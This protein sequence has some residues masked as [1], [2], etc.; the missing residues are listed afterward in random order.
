MQ[1]VDR[2]TLLSALEAVSPG[3]DKKASLVQ[4]DCFVFEDDLV[5]TYNDQT[6]CSIQSPLKDYEG[7]AKAEELLS[8]LGKLTEKELRVSHTDAEVLIE[9]KRRRFGIYQEQEIV[10]PGVGDL[11]EDWS[12]LPPEFGDAINLVRHCVSKEKDKFIIC[13]IHLH[14]E[15]VEATD[16]VQL[17]RYTI[18]TGLKTSYLVNPVAMKHVMELGMDEVGETKTW[19]HFRNQA[20]LVFS[21]R[22]Y[23]DRFPEASHLL[24]GTGEKLKLPQGLGEVLEKVEQFTK[25][26]P[27]DEAQVRVTIKGKEFRVKGQGAHGWYEEVKEINSKLN[28]CFYID[29]KLLET[30]AE[31]TPECQIVGARLLVDNGAFKYATALALA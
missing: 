25:N 19:L 22:K 2:N 21:C 27:D 24:E 7:A 15:Y 30:L 1:V 31:K 6:A 18:R 4:S 17:A 10:L 20:G 23:V 13:C 8:I 9:G 16:N 3:L 26:N 11:P 29:P 12:K 14:P 28:V 5:R